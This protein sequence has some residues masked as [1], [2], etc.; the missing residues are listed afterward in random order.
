MLLQHMLLLTTRLLLHVHYNTAHHILGHST[1][2]PNTLAPIRSPVLIS[3]VRRD[4]RVRQG[5]QKPYLGL[6]L[7]EGLTDTCPIRSIK[8]GQKAFGVG[9]RVIEDTCHALLRQVRAH[10]ETIDVGA[11]RQWEWS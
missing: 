3:H 11:Y 2:P 4:L 1:L 9:K 10:N 8:T 7:E 5:T 6:T